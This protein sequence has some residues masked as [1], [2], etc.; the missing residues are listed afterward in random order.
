MPDSPWGGHR[1]FAYDLVRFVR[2]RLI[3]ELGVHW[4]T[5]FFAFCQAVKDDN[6]STRCIAVDT[7]KGDAHAGYYAENVFESFQKISSEHYAT[8]DIVPLRMVFADALASVQDD[9]VDILHIDGYHTYEAV[10]EDFSSWLCKVAQNGIALFHDVA[11]SSDY[12]SR[13]CW[14]ELRRKHPGFEFRHSY[15]LG[16]LFPKGDARFSAMLRANIEDKAQV[17]EHKAE[18]QA[19]QANQVELERQLAQLGERT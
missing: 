10:S 17:Y 3:V 19:R 6:L 8:V 4:G 15:G 13:R 14:K 12:G 9:S 16:V 11:E 18:L 7:W 2:P 5:S 1:N